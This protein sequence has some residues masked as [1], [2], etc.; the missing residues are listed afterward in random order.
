M[1]FDRATVRWKKTG[2]PVEFELT[3][4]TRQALDDYL[5]A[6]GKKPGEFFLRADVVSVTA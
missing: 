4:Q 3:D 5:K 6:A 1:R 2:R